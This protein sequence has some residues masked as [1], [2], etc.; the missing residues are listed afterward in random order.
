MTY[1]G[2]MVG[3]DQSRAQRMR[4]VARYTVVILIAAIVLGVFVVPR[5]VPADGDRVSLTVHTPAVGPGLEDGSPVILHGAKIGKVTSVGISGDDIKVT[6][7]LD[8][9]RVKGLA[10]D[11]TLDYRPSSYFG[12]TAVN[13]ADAGNTAK[14]GYVRDGD[15]L[16][17]ASGTDYTMSTMIAKGSIIV[18][19]TLTDGMTEAVE[20]ALT[21]TDALSPLLNAGAI[22]ADTVEQTQRALPRENLIYVN[23]VVS[24]LPSLLGGGTDA[25]FSI[26]NSKLRTDFDD[27]V[28]SRL[29][30]GIESV[31]VNFFDL[32]GQVLGSHQ[33]DLLPVV[34]EL[35]AAGSV[36]P[37]IGQGV[38]TTETL[39][40]LLTKLSGAFA[41][42]PGG[43]QI[44]KIRANL[45]YLPGLD[46]PFAGA[47]SAREGG[48]R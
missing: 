46:V 45:K 33:T 36:L 24:A 4:K 26:Y 38:V 14:A 44:L 47:P 30:A 40:T 3:S 48:P 6:L 27:S 25:L 15:D 5:L 28:R 42:G 34:D 22:V 16:A 1:S 32:I 10:R 12:V 41:D 9:D 39:K 23:K 43:S 37:T 7:W 31:A 21:Y 13:I 18:S 29:D 17:L 2:F 11:M 8:K 35:R 20:K 19:G